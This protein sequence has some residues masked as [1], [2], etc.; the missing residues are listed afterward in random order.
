MVFILKSRKEKSKLQILIQ[1]SQNIHISLKKFKTINK[2]QQQTYWNGHWS[3]LRKKLM[4][5]RLYQLLMTTK[6][7]NATSCLS[8]RQ[9]YFQKDFLNSQ[10]AS[11]YS[12][13][14]IILTHHKKRHLLQVVVSLASAKLLQAKKNP[15][16]KNTF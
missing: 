8:K 13:M 14:K 3:Q 16:K 1:K 5:L 6:K 12:T 15:M 11:A 10:T 4:I 2:N 7:S 9:N